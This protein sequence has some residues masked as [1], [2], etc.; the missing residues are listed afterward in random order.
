[1]SLYSSARAVDYRGVKPLWGDAGA[2]PTAVIMQLK[3][4]M[5]PNEMLSP[6]GVLYDGTALLHLEGELDACTA[7]L[8]EFA[9][10]ELLT[11]RPNQLVVDVAGLDFCDATG[12]R[13]L[14]AARDSCSAHGT[15]FSLVGLHPRL[16][17]MLALLQAA[18]LLAPSGQE[19]LCAAEGDPLH[20]HDLLPDVLAPVRGTSAT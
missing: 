4:I 3:V 5:H 20:S 19:N 2:I 11:R 10:A 14:L 17:K 16:R 8:V 18:R 12:L 9:V 6:R 1:M 13:I 7:P 15:A